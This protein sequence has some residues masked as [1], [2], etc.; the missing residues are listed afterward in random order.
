MSSKCD[1]CAKNITKSRPGIECS[2]CEK[3][4]H[5]S[6]QC[7]GLT[8]KQLAALKA[9]ENLDWTCQECQ[10]SSRRRSIIMPDDDEEDETYTESSNVPIDIKKLLADI[11]KEVEKAIKRELKEITLSLQYNS[12]KMDELI[13]NIEIIQ[14]NIHNLQK[15]NV[16]LTNRNN[17][18]E[19]RVGALEQRIQDMEQQ[20]LR[21]C[22]E[23][24]NVPLRDDENLIQIAGKT[25]KLLNQNNDDVKEV[26]RLPGR[27]DR[28][29]PILVELKTDKIQTSWIAATKTKIGKINSS[30]IVPD[31]SV[32]TS[33]GTIFVC[34]AL[35]SFNKQL[36][37]HA[38]QELRNTYRYI[39]IKKGVL[40][41]RKEG[42]EEKPY[43]IRSGDDIKKLSVKS[44]MATGK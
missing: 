11:S 19:V 22:I 15:K 39:W 31:L 9:A 12:D 32:S 34:E 43:I 6:N 26:K 2:R 42:V 36:L 27:K 29:G 38:K 16:E 4:V 18:L 44:N 7:T 25:A 10:N 1:N 5:L 24:H 37:W 14:G 13:K 41:V 8:N 21:T 23:L 30:D 17:H 33:N 28:P 40:R 20:E 3:I 35:T